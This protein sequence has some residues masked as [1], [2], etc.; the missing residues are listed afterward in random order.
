MMVVSA[1]GVGLAYVTHVLL[2]QWLGVE[3]YGHYVYA[4]A[5]LN[6]LVTLV[7]VGMNTSTVRLTAE[8]RAAQNHAAILGLSRFSTLVVL[9]AG[10]AV[11]LIGGLALAALD[12]RGIFTPAQVQTLAI[13]LSLVVVLGLLNQRMAILQGFERVAQAHSFLEIVRPLLLIGILAALLPLMEIQSGLAMGAN[14]AATG[15]ALL[16]VTVVVAR[17]LKREGPARGLARQYHNRA[18]LAL[19]LPYLAIGGLTVVMDQ[20]DIL[21]LGTL[22]GG[23]A[24][25]L[26]LPA[27]KLSQLLLFPMLAIRSHAAP[28]LAKLHAQNNIVELQRQMNTITVSSALVGIVLMAGI[29]WQREFLLSLFGAEFIEAA[30]AIV[31]LSLG[32]MVFAITGG[33]EVFLIIGPFERVTMLIYALVVALNIVLNLLLIPSFGFMGAA[34]AT[35]ATIVVRGLI[36]TFVVWRR[37]GVLPWASVSDN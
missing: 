37:T 7:Q 3:S 22:M 31:V 27:I 30:P 8:L 23:A 25:G 16:F 19:S 21:I 10:C 26:Y 28:L 14:F 2:A 1:I 34:Y 5:W 13:T 15:L 6:V 17:L 12:G 24:A 4:L 18:W 36:S 33:V 29:I 35:A 9:A 32:M 11:V 20:S